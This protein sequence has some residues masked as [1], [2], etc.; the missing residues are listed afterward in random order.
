MSENFKWHQ[1]FHLQKMNDPW[2]MCASY[3]YC[4]KKKKVTVMSMMIDHATYH[5]KSDAT[6]N[7]LPKKITD[8]Y[9]N[10]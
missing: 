9:K 3:L 7:K 5:D 10:G 4:S 2:V 1:L 8:T 6:Y